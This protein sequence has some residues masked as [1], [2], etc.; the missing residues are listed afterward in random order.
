MEVLNVDLHA[1][2]QDFGVDTLSV[3]VLPRAFSEVCVDET[4]VELI[5]LVYDYVFPVRHSFLCD[6]VVYVLIPH[7]SLEVGEGNHLQRIQEFFSS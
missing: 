6:C 3:L 4:E 1:L 7:S 2:V 5:V